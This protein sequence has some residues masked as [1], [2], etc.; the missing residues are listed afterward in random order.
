[1]IANF[2]SRLCRLQSFPGLQST[3]PAVERCLHTLGV[4]PA[5]L[6]YANQLQ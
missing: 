6:G 4:M 1:M 3:Y 5:K 2:V